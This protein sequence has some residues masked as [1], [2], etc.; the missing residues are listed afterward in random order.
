MFIGC[1][2]GAEPFAYEW[3][4]PFDGTTLD[5]IVPIGGCNYQDDKITATRCM[6]FDAIIL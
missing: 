5:I 4:V 6:A 3:S 2:D 1:R